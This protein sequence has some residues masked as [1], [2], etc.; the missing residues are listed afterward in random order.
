MGMSNKEAEGH[1]LSSLFYFVEL[2]HYNR[3]RKATETQ[4][5]WLKWNFNPGCRLPVLSHSR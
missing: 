1:R 3:S 5:Q 2:S 4:E